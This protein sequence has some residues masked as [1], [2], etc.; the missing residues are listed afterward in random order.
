MHVMRLGK[1]I[2]VPPAVQF[3]QFSLFDVLISVNSCCSDCLESNRARRPENK[4]VQ[5]TCSE[6]TLML[7][8]CEK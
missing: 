1:Q 4:S 2:S 3:E 6:I 5:E 8:T 7:T